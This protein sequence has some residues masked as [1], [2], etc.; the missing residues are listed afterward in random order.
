MNVAIY[1][2]KSRA[3]EHLDTAEVLQRHREQLLALAKSRGYHVVRIYEEVVSGGKLQM[4]PQMMEL[5]N[6]VENNL[7]DGVMCMDIDRLGRGSMVEQGLIVETFRDSDTLIITLDKI[8]DLSNE[9]D[10]TEVEFKAFFS[11]YE[12]KAISRRMRVGKIKTVKDGYCLSEPSF[13]YERDY[14]NGRPSLKVNEEQAGIVRLIFNLYT[15][16]R[17]GCQR[18]ANYLNSL[19]VKTRK[20]TPFTRTS[21][22]H[23][24]KNEIYIG[25]VIYNRINYTFKDGKKIRKKVNSRDDWIIGEGEFPKLITE[26]QFHLASEIMKQNSTVPLPLKKEPNN[27]LAG[28]IV[29]GNCGKNMQKQGYKKDVANVLL[30]CVTP[31]CQKGNR[32]DYVEAEILN[33]LRAFLNTEFDDVEPEVSD[34]EERKNIARAELKKLRTQKE[35]LHDLLEQGVYTIDVFVSRNKILMEKIETIEETLK[36]LSVAAPKIDY[37]TTKERI[38]HVL[39]VYGTSDIADKNTYMKSILEKVVYHKDKSWCGSSSFEL[40]IYIKYSYFE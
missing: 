6:D 1:L 18:I 40:S 25:H 34:R 19:G 2:R 7:Y 39:S 36:E 20:G 9:S 29:C 5:L 8:H 31:G 15:S 24:L 14:V 37:E 28:I 12:Y 17:L 13:G 32:F 4:R 16:D 30:Y 38:R 23:I 35:S 3:E 27:P 10:E 21:V 26:E 33:Q 22:R 11:R